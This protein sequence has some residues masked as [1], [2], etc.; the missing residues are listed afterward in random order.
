MPQFINTNISSL[1]AQRNL[2][3]S[4]AASQTAMQRLSSGLR[5]NSAKDDAAGLSISARMSSQITGLNMAAR[6]S[7]DGISMSQTAEGGLSSIS[8]SLQRIRELAVQSA[9][10]SNTDADRVS[11]QGEATQLLSEIDR[12]STQT[13]FNGRALLDGT[14]TDQKFQVGANAG[15]TISMSV[16]S[17]KINKLGSTD[18]ASITSAQNA[19]TNALVAGAFTLN[20]V[21][22]GPSLAAA[23]TASTASAEASSIAKA[24]AVNAVS[25]QSGVTATVNE[26]DVAGSTMTVGGGATLSGSIVLNDVT[27]DM[28]TVVN[29]NSATRAGVVSAINAQQGL[30]GVTAEDTGDDNTGVKLT[31]ADGR[32][33]VT[34]TY[35]NVTAA[36]TGLGAAGTTNTGSFTLNSDKAI[37]I[38]SNLTGDIATGGIKAAGLQIGT[39]DAQTAYA[40]TTSVAGGA[41]T[42]TRIVAGDF[43]INNVSIGTSLASS[44]TASYSF[45]AVS[46]GAGAATAD[47]KALSGIAK[48]AAINA[49]SGQTGVTATANATDIQGG[50]TTAADIVHS[51]VLLINGVATAAIAT[52]ATTTTIQQRKATADAI[53][54]ISG[55]TGVVATDTN[56]DTKG[57]T[58][59]A[60][61]GR[62]IT[63]VQA[64][65][66]TLAAADTGLGA[67]ITVAGAVPP[68]PTELDAGTVTSTVTLS[69]TKAFTLNAGPTGIGT[70]A[71]NLNVGTYGA[72]RSGEALDK[73]DISTLAGANKA[74]TALDNALNSVNASVSNM[75]AIQN[76]FTSVVSNLQSTTENLTASRS[77]IQDAD[78]AAESAQLSRTSI[79][80]QAGTAM[81]AQANQSSAGVMALL[82]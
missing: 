78:F 5:I 14:L 60:A 2:N 73:L 28:T 62:N 70:V 65:G 55:Q 72:G 31:A 80:Q 10:A 82:R 43:K 33:I 69:S 17:A 6:N 12:V 32:N 40:S 36:L 57:V 29:N 18:A 77:R 52:T 56:D 61:D 39:Y 8:D 24:A 58:L 25:A 11:M 41:N 3:K 42:L 81:L 16:A 76:R 45:I 38:T 44:D 63:T 79:L 49:I 22:V 67:N 71:L 64:K 68:T 26:T 66:G 53:N 13:Q 37:A 19:S 23:D 15:Q 30:T 4:Q 7:T 34:G 20:G 9:N 50:T 75:G 21:Q 48:A 59:S 46:T 74:L 47:S 54:A 1:N 35:T 27:I 51:G